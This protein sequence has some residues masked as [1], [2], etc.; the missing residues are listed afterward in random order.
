MKKEKFVA[1]ICLSVLATLEASAS[2]PY[3]KIDKV[4]VDPMETLVSNWRPAPFE[5]KARVL[6]FSECFG[7]NHHGGRCY[8][9]HL[10]KRAGE[11]YGAWETVQETNSVRLGDAAYLAGFDAV[12]FNNST[13]INETNAPGVTAAMTDFLARGK[14]IA[15][16]HAGLD[17]FKDSETLQKTF[18]GFFKGHPWHEDGSWKFKVEEPDHPLVAPFEELG[19]TFYKAD[20]IYQFLRHFDRSSC[21]VLISVDLS[22]PVTKRAEMWWG[23]TFGPGSTREDHDYG[24][25]WI[26]KVGSGRVFYTS[27]GH[28]RGAYLDAPRAYHMLLGVQFA[29]GDIEY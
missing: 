25:S 29:L 5:G 11:V 10:V 18:G 21:K 2:W 13:K 20:E 7:Y 8:G 17:S 23:K 4:D 14:G 3:D 6:L 16:I 24:V 15:I 9:D 22:D 26:K 28:D 19:P 1:V 27:F 12:I